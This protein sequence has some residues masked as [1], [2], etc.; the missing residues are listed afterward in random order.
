[1]I[2]LSF[3]SGHIEKEL[4]ISKHKELNQVSFGGFIPAFTT[5]AE[6]FVI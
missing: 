5:R 6:N 4:V 3:Q 2:F 1:L